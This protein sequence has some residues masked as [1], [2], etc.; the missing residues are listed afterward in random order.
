MM[1]R[2]CVIC[3]ESILEEFGKLKGT[4]LKV[5]NLN[6]KAEFIFVCSDCQKQKDW[7]ERAKIKGA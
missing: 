2:N 7:V 5:L 3:N 6:K 1:E 4:I